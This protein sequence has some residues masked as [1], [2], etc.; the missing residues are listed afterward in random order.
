[1]C[2][3]RHPRDVINDPK[4]ARSLYEF[5]LTGRSAYIFIYMPYFSDK[6]EADEEGRTALHVAARDGHMGCVYRLAQGGTNVLAQDKSGNTALHL[7][8]ENGHTEVA[9]FLASKRFYMLST[10]NANG[11]TASD[12][13]VLHR[14]VC[15]IWR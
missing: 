15:L 13:A 1:M 6:D 4:A 14:R 10:R 11:Q 12:L 3:Q 5:A 2:Y 8:A 7:A 9:V